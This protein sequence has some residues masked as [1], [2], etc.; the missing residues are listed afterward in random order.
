MNT[1]YHTKLQ[2]ITTLQQQQQR[3]II[4]TVGTVRYISII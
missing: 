1:I 2:N 3:P 4:M